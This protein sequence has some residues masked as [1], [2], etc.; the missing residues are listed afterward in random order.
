MS[1][2]CFKVF[3]KVSCKCYYVSDNVIPFQSD[4]ICCI[5]S[6]VVH[7]IIANVDLCLYICAHMYSK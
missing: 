3:P 1:E 4:E 6:T 7:F 5:W 2:R